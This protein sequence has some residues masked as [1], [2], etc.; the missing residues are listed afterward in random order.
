MRFILLLL[1][2][3]S[4]ASVY[5][6]NTHNTPMFRESGEFQGSVYAA[7]GVD[8]QA[9]YAVTDHIALMGNYSFL[10][11]KQTD[12]ELQNPDYT[13]K[14][15]FWEG[16]LG[17]FEATK[18]TRYELYA[19]Y[20]MGTGTSASQ[21][22]FFYSDFGQ[23]KIVATGNYSR[24]FIQPAIGTNHKNF[25][26]TFAPRFT[27]V[28][29]SDFTSSGITREPDEKPQLFAEPALSSKFTIVGNL[30]GVLQLG[31]TLGFPNDVYF[32]YESFQASAGIQLHLGNR[33]R[34]RVY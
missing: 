34:T 26:L 4:C 3:S 15:S 18:N 30:E 33:L 16:G 12:E 11:S 6:P 23:Q 31:I 14:N 27:V 1:L 5:L 32:E 21:Y 8:V 9:A 13:R 17:V 7:A 22:Y 24:I 29:F 19:G 28:K 20:G 2:T 25:N 10:S